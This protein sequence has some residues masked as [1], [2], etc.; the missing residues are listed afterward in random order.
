MQNK[1]PYLIAVN[2]ILKIFWYFQWLF[3]LALIVISF[4]IIVNP[5]CIDVEKIRGFSVD[6]SRIYLGEVDLNDGINHTAFISNG[7]GR[8]HISQ[9]ENKFVLYRIIGAAIDALIYILVI[10]YLRKIFASLKTGVFFIRS[11]GIYIKK[12]AYA[13]LVLSFLPELYYYLIASHI[14]KNIE[15]SNV[16]LNADFNLDFRTIFLGL[17]IFIISKAFIR[18]AELKEEVDLT[19]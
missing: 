9:Y 8:L 16:V 2:I 12:I 18:G 6:F 1:Y 13:V 17:L 14:S 4:T 5:S 15:L 3:I 11:N 7:Y 19:V 10:Y